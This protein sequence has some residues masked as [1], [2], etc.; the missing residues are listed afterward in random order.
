MPSALQL[1]VAGS[2]RGTVVSMGCSIIRGE[3]DAGVLHEME[4]RK[5]SFYSISFYWK[6]CTTEKKLK[7]IMA[8]KFYFIFP[9]YTISFSFQSRV[10]PAITVVL[11]STEKNVAVENHFT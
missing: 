9:F 7:F 8:F 5:S 4:E 3:F 6:N 1:R 2:C 11:F 10:I